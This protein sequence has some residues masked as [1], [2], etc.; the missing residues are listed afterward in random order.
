V[1][2]AVAFVELVLD[3]AR[4]ERP[5]KGLLGPVPLL[6]AAELVL[7]PRRELDADVELEAL[8][9]EER[10][11]EAAEELV[12]DLLVCA[13][14]VGVVLHEVA[15]AQEAVKDAGALVAVEVP[16]LGQPQ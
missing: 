16:G 6:L 9:Q 11:V 5:T 8:V 14:D 2:G 1:E 10:V 3:A 7:G 13:E 15:H 4:L 12:V